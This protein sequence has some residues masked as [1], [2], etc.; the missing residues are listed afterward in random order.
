MQVPVS[1]KEENDLPT[2]W[3]SLPEPPEGV[4]DETEDAAPGSS[5]RREPERQ[6]A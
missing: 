1:I 5:E 2:H 4:A 6:S 3:Q